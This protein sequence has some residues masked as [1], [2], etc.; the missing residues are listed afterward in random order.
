MPKTVTIKS[1]MN[2]DDTTS[3]NLENELKKLNLS[4]IP[5]PVA[6]ISYATHPASS[7]ETGAQPNVDEEKRKLFIGSISLT[8]TGEELKNHFSKYGEVERVNIN[9]D[10]KNGQTQGYAFVVFKN[11]NVVEKVLASGDSIF[12]Y[13][14][15]KQIEERKK[16]KPRK[17][18]TNQN[19]AVVNGAKTNGVKNS[20]KPG[21]GENVP[22]SEDNSNEHSNDETKQNDDIANDNNKSANTRKRKRNKAKAGKQYVLVENI[23][24]LIEKDVS[25]FFTKYNVDIYYPVDDDNSNKDYCILST[26]DKTQSD[27][28]LK[29][30]RPIINGIKLRINPMRNMPDDYLSVKNRDIEDF[31]LFH[32]DDENGE[33]VLEPIANH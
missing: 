10:F 31:K 15:N 23:I 21:K 29:I 16:I 27:A 32:G 14:N 28:I 30:S 26:N 22:Q 1:N 24:H 20:K 33:V 12:D 11:K 9:Y 13:S 25:T 5:C 6:E 2:I 18:K 7:L 8:T 3:L 17:S 4:N 19:D